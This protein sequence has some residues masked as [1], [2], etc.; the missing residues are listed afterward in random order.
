MRR[1]SWPIRVENYD[2]PPTIFGSPKA[3]NHGLAKSASLVRPLFAISERVAVDR[4]GHAAGGAQDRIARRRIPL[5]GAAEAR[6]DVRLAA[7][8]QAEFQRRA[9]R[10]ERLPRR[11][12]SAIPVSRPC[13]WRGWRRPRA[14]WRGAGPNRP[15]RPGE[16]MVDIGAPGAPRA[17]AK[18]WPSA[19]A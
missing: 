6:I 10:N 8:D 7:G 16:A 2:Q 19:G 11:T 15:Q 4:R 13:S 14:V 3:T 17:D 9:A 18:I 5:H 12:A 1:G